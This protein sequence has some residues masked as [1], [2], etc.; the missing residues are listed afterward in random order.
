MTILDIGCGTGAITADIAKA[1]GPEGMVLGVDR[2]DA[3]LAIAI[4]EHGGIGNLRFESADILTLDVGNRFDSNFDIVTA[5]RTIQW[6]SEPKRA[7]VNMKKAAKPEGHLIVLDYNLDETRWE[8]EPPALFRRFYQAF[9]DWRTANNWDNRTA[10]HLSEFFHSA[11]LVDIASHPTDEL[12]RRGDPDFFDAYASGIWLY[13]I[14]TL[15]P[16]LVQAGF[17]EEGVRLRA[18][19]D[20]SNYVQRTLRLQRHSML[21]VDG[22]IPP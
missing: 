17:L 20:Y 3:N 6:I 5:A 11:G 19:E 13:V 15:G 22:R 8:P 2:D 10:S 14:Q 21:T 7:I 12:V 9:L 18:E 16:N 1:V 4:Q